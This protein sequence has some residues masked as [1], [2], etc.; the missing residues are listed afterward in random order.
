MGVP[1]IGD[2]L[3]Q[4]VIPVVTAALLAADGG[5]DSRGR[6]AVLPEIAAPVRP[7]GSPDVNTVCVIQSTFRRGSARMD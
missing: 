5:S 1:G 6:P 2:A 7:P 3:R 4:C